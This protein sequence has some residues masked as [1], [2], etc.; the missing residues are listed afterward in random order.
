MN[1]YINHKNYSQFEE[2]YG[3]K[4]VNLIYS[5][6]YTIPFVDEIENINL[7]PKIRNLLFSLKQEKTKSDIS[8]N[9]KEIF[10]DDLSPNDIQFLTDL[11]PAIATFKSNGQIVFDALEVQNNGIEYHEAFHRIFRLYLNNKERKEIIEEVERLNPD[12][13]WE[14]YDRLTKE[15]QIE[16]LLAD[17]FMLFSLE[18]KEK[19]NKINSF[20]SKLLKFLKSLFTRPEK[21]ESIYD[22]ILNGGYRSKFSA[23]QYLYDANKFKFEYYDHINKSRRN[24]EMS[25]DQINGIT[26]YLVQLFNLSLQKNNPYEYLK[27]GRDITE[28]IEEMIDSIPN[29][30][31]KSI[32]KYNFN[33]KSDG[34]RV[35]LFDKLKSIGLNLEAKVKTE[36]VNEDDVEQINEDNVEQIMGKTGNDISA[37]DKAAFSEDPR[38]TLSAL[39]KLKFSTL[40]KSEGTVDLVLDFG[41]TKEKISLPKYYNFEQVWKQTAKVLTKSPP[42]IEAMMYVLDKSKEIKSEIKDQIWEYFNEIRTQNTELASEFVSN[43]TLT[44]YNFAR[45]L[46]ENKKYVIKELTFGKVGGTL[47]NEYANT[48]LL[49]NIDEKLPLKFNQ[50]VENLPSQIVSDSAEYNKFIKAFKDKFEKADDIKLKDFIIALKAAA[51]GKSLENYYRDSKVPDSVIDFKSLFTKHFSI[52]AA[53]EGIEETMHQTIDGENM[54]DISLDTTMSRRFK[55][56]QF[57]SETLPVGFKTNITVSKLE[58]YFKLFKEVKEN[59]NSEDENNLDIAIEKVKEAGGQDYLKLILLKYYDPSLINSY[60]FGINSRGE[61]ELRSDL[62]K[63]LIE[64]NLKGGLYVVD[65]LM[66]IASINQQGKT[67]GELNE[68]DLTVYLLNNSNLGVLDTIKHSDRS[69]FYAVKFQGEQGVNTDLYGGVAF[70][71]NVENIANRMAAIMSDNLFKNERTYYNSTKGSVISYQNSY[72]KNGRMKNSFDGIITKASTIEKLEALFNSKQE[73]SA[74]LKAEVA[75]QIKEWFY[76]ETIK[77]KDSWKTK[78]IDL[79]ILDS[80]GEVKKAFEKYIV[81]INK[82]IDIVIASAFFN[83][84][85]FHMEEQKLLYGHVSQYN[86]ADNFYKRMN[87]HSGTGKSFDLSNTINQD[88]FFDNNDLEFKIKDLDGGEF[89]LNSYKYSDTKPKLTIVTLQEASDYVTNDLNK[90]EK[91]LEESFE[92][93]KKLYEAEGKSKELIKKIFLKNKERYTSPL[94]EMNVPDGQSYINLLFFKEYKKRLSQWDDAKEMAF[95]LEM[96][97]YELDPSDPDIKQKIA[98]KMYNFYASKAAV[99]KSTKLKLLE[100]D[101]KKELSTLQ[102]RLDKKIYSEEDYNEKLKELEKKNKNDIFKIN[103]EHTVQKY[104]EN[105]LHSFEVL[106]PQYGGPT[107]LTEERNLLDPFYYG[108]VKTSFFPLVPSVV[109]GTNLHKLSV[110]MIKNGVDIVSLQSATKTG[111]IDYSQFAEVKSGELPE[112]FGV[113]TEEEKAEIL[114]KLKSEGLQAYSSDGKYNSTISNIMP[115]IVQYLDWYYLKDQVKIHEHPDKQ[116]RNSTQSMKNILANLF[117][118]V[119]NKS[120]PVDALD[121]KD[122]WENMDESEKEKVSDLYKYVNIYTK[123]IKE[124]I[125]E[126]LKELI[127]ELDYSDNKIKNLS[128]FKRMLVSAAQ[129]RNSPINVIEAVELFTDGKYKTIIETMPNKGKIEPIIYKLV[130]KIISFKRPGNSVPMVSS[131]MFESYFKSDKVDRQTVS[132]DLLKSYRLENDKLAPA[133]IML[134]LP[135]YMFGKV[136]QAMNNYHEQRGE[137]KRYDNIFH[138]LVKYNELLESGEK[139]FILKGL[140]IPN[141]QYSSTD[142]LKVKKFF[143]PTLE[144]FAIVYPE[145]VAKT[146]GDSSR[147]FHQYKI[148]K[149]G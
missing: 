146:G 27:N 47:I 29:K 12:K 113:K 91:D 111:A 7:D 37:F 13:P 148:K 103:K 32:V 90:F 130:S 31:L 39:V 40:V 115:N 102:D 89:E 112:F 123:T 109:L 104:F 99:E 141:Q 83:S 57:I 132:G 92:Y 62:L 59:T 9:L 126:D 143:I 144:S 61:L 100:Y 30:Y 60:T 129:D 2:V 67:L 33:F 24:V 81:G 10:G 43:F 11:G 88:I 131:H 142:I 68:A 117:V 72:F 114:S 73:P 140:R 135:H 48:L 65:G 86:S 119:N 42:D 5:S 139:N 3:D 136:I 82:G 22:K 44:N 70:E 64:G 128:T 133:E 116:I 106:K 79:G 118:V 71:D 38:K 8:N 17:D 105:H 95:Q 108:I 58:D 19:F 14:K 52:L 87:T 15:E 55:I 21:L 125:D 137:E 49:S 51:E 96:S 1:C 147:S 50:L 121:F 53:E 77:G 78:M 45:A 56:L 35:K 28:I 16:E 110:D 74:E 145:I 127:K 101:Y 20:F 26:N 94:K 107:S 75:E 41:T 6:L 124:I 122:Q 54:N 138:A 66:D 46:L 76:S 69:T 18:R 84:S 85:I 120:I 36:E 98:D 4:G 23:E 80:N 25:E 134:P 93:A 63:K 34:I 97:L 149:F